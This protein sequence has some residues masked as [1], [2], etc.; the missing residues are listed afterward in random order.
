MKQRKEKL[1]VGLLV[2]AFGLCAAAASVE[3]GAISLDGYYKSYASAYGFPSFSL[4]GYSIDPPPL[5]AVSNR[6]R[7][8]LRWRVQPWVSVNAAYDIEGRVQDPILFSTD[9]LPGAVGRAY[10]VDD[11][12]QRL[13]PVSSHP[14]RSF[15]LMQ[16]LDRAQLDFRLGRLDLYVG[17]QA[18]AWGTARVI[19]PTDILAPFS[20][21]TL[22]TEDRVGID[23]IRARVPIGFMSEL[24]IGLVAGKD[25][26]SKE[27]AACVRYKTYIAETDL[28]GIV[29]GFREHFMVGIDAARSIGGAGSWLEAAVVW[30]KLLQPEESLRPDPYWRVSV[31]ADYNFGA[32]TYTFLE[33][34]YNQPGSDDPADYVALTSTSAYTDGAVYLLGEHYLA[35]GV[36]RQITALITGT[37][38]ILWNLS[39]GSAYVS[40]SVE[41]NLAENVYLAGG[42]YVG[43]G[44]GPDG[45]LRLRSEFGSY[46]DTFYSA[47]RYYF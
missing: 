12:D 4:G 24:D 39:D 21:A 19:N 15:A 36:Q 40:A 20:Y 11:L 13:Y 43:L 6:L 14:V 47:F 8:D 28:T 3:A 16:N 33:Y 35:P 34:H 46:P 26:K 42:G 9:L 30:P 22:D 25:A 31:G 10:R 45:P 44:E 23:A 27:S 32:N 29:A 7:V 38:Q 2:I 18:I 17:R 1:F 5:G 41:Y 37:A